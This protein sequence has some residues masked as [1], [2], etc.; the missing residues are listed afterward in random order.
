ME[1]KL[2]EGESP[3]D[4]A[5]MAGTQGKRDTDRGGAGASLRGSSQN[6]VKKKNKRRSSRDRKPE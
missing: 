5:G 1:E 6:N 4:R 3:L 2:L